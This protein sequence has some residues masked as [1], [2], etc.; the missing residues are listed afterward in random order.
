M[1]QCIGSFSHA[2]FLCFYGKEFGVLCLDA[3]VLTGIRPAEVLQAA[4]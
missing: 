1:S 4:E 3:A 2:C